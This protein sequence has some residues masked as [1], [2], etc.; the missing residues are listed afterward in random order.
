MDPNAAVDKIVQLA[1]ELRETGG[2]S[3]IDYLDDLLE[4]ISGLATWLENDGFP[5]SPRPTTP[6]NGW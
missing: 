3:T 1:N 6:R 2:E 4:V 5:P